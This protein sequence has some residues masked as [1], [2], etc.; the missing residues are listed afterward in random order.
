MLESRPH[1]VAVCK[2]CTSKI[3]SGEI[4][5][6]QV[7]VGEAGVFYDELVEDREFEQA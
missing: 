3:G 6:L 1:E 2:N 7:A 5:L 4:G